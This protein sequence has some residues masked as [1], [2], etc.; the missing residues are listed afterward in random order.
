MIF[1]PKK[2]ASS[3][4][5]MSLI[6]FPA[7]SY[8]KISPPK[9]INASLIKQ[10]IL[11]PDLGNISDKFEGSSDKLVIQI[12]DMH[13]NPFVQR[14]ISDIIKY[15]GKNLNVSCIF[16]EGYWG[17][18]DISPVLDHPADMDTKKAFIKYFFDKGQITGSEYF[19][20][21]NQPAPT[22]YGIEEKKVYDLNRNIFQTVMMSNLQPAVYLETMANKI[23]EAK[24]LSLPKKLLDF[25]KEY[26]SFFWNKETDIISFAK[27]LKIYLTE[28]GI[29]NKDYPVLKNFF[30]LIDL[31]ESVKPQK[32]ITE[33]KYFFDEIKL[34]YD[35][36]PSKNISKYYTK[37]LLGQI[38][39][40]DF[41]TY[42]DNF[43]KNQLI[44][45]D[46]YPQIKLQL[47]LSELH[48]NINPSELI[49]AIH[50]V[51]KK[52]MLFLSNSDKEIFL[53][54]S[55]DYINL[56]KRLVG[57]NLT[58]IELS[59]LNQA[60]QSF[61]LNKIFSDLELEKLDIAKP[62][63]KI[64]SCINNAKDFYKISQKRDA[65]LS[66]NTIDYMKQNKVDIAIQITG[67]FH[68]EKILKKLKDE[69]ISY[70]SINPR[71][72]LNLNNTLYSGFM[73]GYQPFLERIIGLDNLQ[74]NNLA[75]E[76]IA[77]RLIV[78][79]LDQVEG[80][81]FNEQFA[82]SFFNLLTTMKKLDFEAGG[83]ILDLF[84]SSTPI[85]PETIDNII[86]GDMSSQDRSKMLETILSSVSSPYLDPRYLKKLKDEGYLDITQDALDQYEQNIN[87]LR[88]IDRKNR[89]KLVKTIQSKMNGKMTVEPTPVKRSFD[90]VKTVKKKLKNKSIA[91]FSPEMK[92]LGG[93]R[94]MFWGGLGVLAGEYVEGLADTGINT[95]GVTL[96]YS[97]VVKQT[98]TDDGV[99]ITQELPVDYS[100]LPVFDTGVIINLNDI[101]IPVRARVWEI[102]V[103]DARVFALQDLTSDVTRM[104]YGGATE[105]PQLRA[106]QDQLLG[107]GG[108]E[109][110][111]Q[112]LDKGIIN[113]IPAILH[114]NEANCIFLA[115]EVMQRQIF[116][117]ELDPNSYWKN[118][119]LAFTTHTPVPAGLPTVSSQTFKTDNVMHM[120]W[121][122]GI[123][124][125]TLMRLYSKYA[126]G[127]T[128]TE[129]D[130][131]QR[132][133]LV[134][135]MTSD[136]DT[137]IKQFKDFAGSSN[138][139]LNLTEAAATLADISSSVSLRHESV[140][141][142]EIIKVKKTPSRFN[143]DEKVSSNGITNGVNLHDWQPPEFQQI[144]PDLIPDETLVSVKQREKKEFINM[145]NSRSGS[146]LSA[147][148]LT[149]SVMRRTNTYKRT[150][151][152][153][154]NID[155][156]AEELKDKYG[157]QQINIVFSG[158]SHPKDEPGKA[159]FK[160]IQD[161]VK[162][163][164]PTIHIAFVEQ[165]DISIAKY[166][167]RGSDIWLMMPV[168]KMEA[169]STSH[170]KA[171]G[172]GTM[173]ISSFD[174]AMIEEVD[175]II[176]D[177]ANANGAFITPLILHRTVPKSKLHF[178]GSNISFDESI[179]YYSHPQIKVNGGQP[180]IPVAVIEKDD[181]Y[182]IIDEFISDLSPENLQKIIA[183]NKIHL[184]ESDFDLSAA[185][186]DD[187]T[188][189]KQGLYSLYFKS[190]DPFTTHQL[191]KLYL[192]NPA[193]WYK[194]LYQKI[195]SIA[196]IY[197]SAQ[198]GNPQAEASYV[199]M[200][201]NSVKRSYEVDI[202]RMALEYIQLK[203]SNILKSVESRNGNGNNIL[204]TLIPE[205]KLQKRI[206]NRRQEIVQAKQK[207]FD[208]ALGNRLV[209]GFADN[210]Q[211]TFMERIT[212]DTDQN[213]N[214]TIAGHPITIETDIQFGNV[215]LPIDVKA[216]L[217][218]E[219][220]G[221]APQRINMDLIKRIDP[222]TK[223]FRYQA[224]IIPQTAGN[225]TFRIALEP[226][227]P[228]MIAH[229]KLAREFKGK[230]N[231][232]GVPIDLKS[233]N[234]VMDKNLDENGL[235]W[236]ADQIIVKVMEPAE[237]APTIAQID[238]AIGRE[239]FE[240]S[241]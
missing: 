240:L 105:T 145:V 2:M 215:I 100:K 193:P 201:R 35:N 162:R 53:L 112:L 99:Q 207:E 149:I 15:I 114:M 30:S 59:W 120:G 204:Q 150:D 177:P 229:M 41:F 101:G 172:G 45:S 75:P 96:L 197:Y 65:I 168:E 219:A 213:D 195:S 179:G 146:N 132:K 43:I 94:S 82:K 151:L 144:D 49:N 17:V 238:K 115:D 63:E 142:S 212:T 191:M 164:H 69:N 57:L 173:V 126:Y 18:Y 234:I 110:L 27:K 85:S 232:A 39:S 224:T 6:F 118:V 80:L 92:L 111:Q 93:I 133:R 84:K 155:L 131:E 37:Y 211:G 76:L 239:L 223:K 199:N 216:V 67:G 171:L 230:E 7:L 209:W 203:Y 148:Y 60:E 226:I 158:I 152:I 189:S 23:Y 225:Y 175:D 73:T 124:S 10:I 205:K 91:Y 174:G 50:T 55:L 156:L 58:A 21:L 29:K 233:V 127:K 161:A 52:I 227:N 140:T 33:L 24:S 169:S 208:L 236:S 241:L 46:E 217:E 16:V 74:V 176:T 72:T 44:N 83:T 56:L 13:S 196:D 102:P 103:G 25:H 42:L 121:L 108:I 122:L 40:I 70:I 170:Q 3:A 222:I 66:R 139:V 134:E 138:I 220:P 77:V 87:K 125:V 183:E 167:V 106:Q 190:L 129:L 109:A 81:T 128:W 119:G 54:D 36:Q 9:N 90:K 147:D 237:K 202:R 19:A 143:P 154:K 235:K 130:G 20:F 113:H 71:T 4:L 198:R 136:V 97:N 14:N 12:K 107:R 200:I 98:L 153:L 64:F 95:Y 8:S 78:Q 221:T 137:L 159:M 51:S 206:I 123:D 26:R 185:L 214:V 47:E 88:T 116:K 184:A 210:N 180:F 117:D 188:I 166:G 181:N 218:Y 160:N 5:L 141:N 34:S 1:R 86:S 89:H 178:I 31:E 187:G 231:Q 11:P 79:A 28:S 192:D 22:I 48:Q 61:S 228:Q 38:G 135:I 163:K 165:Y 186:Q 194:L 104:L 62:S 32:L 68:S 182:I 157:D